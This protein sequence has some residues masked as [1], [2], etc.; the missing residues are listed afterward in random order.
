[1]EGKQVIPA[2]GDDHQNQGGRGCADGRRPDDHGQDGCLAVYRNRRCHRTGKPIRRSGGGHPLHRSAAV[3]RR[4]WR[5]VCKEVR[6]P[7]L[8]N[9]VEGGKTPILTAAGAS[10][11]RLQHRRLSPSRPSMPRP[12]GFRSAMEA[13]FKTGSTAGCMDRMVTFA[14]FNHLVGLE[15]VRATETHYCRELFEK[16]TCGDE[17]YCSGL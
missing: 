15:K 11:D 4:R 17:C 9:M 13:L 14:D 2:D 6:A 1:M 3:G 12:T 10:G 7:M 16:S 5:R 8:A